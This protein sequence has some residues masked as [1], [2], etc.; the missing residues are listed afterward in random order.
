MKNSDLNTYGFV[1]ARWDLHIEIKYYPK[2][3]YKSKKGDTS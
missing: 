1:K 3:N 2:H